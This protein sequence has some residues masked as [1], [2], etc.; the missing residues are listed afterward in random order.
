[1]A[2]D[3]SKESCACRG[4]RN[5]RLCPCLQEVAMNAE[6][7]SRCLR[8]GSGTFLERRRAVVGVSLAAMG[9]LGLIALYQIGVIAHLPDPPLPGFDADKVHGSA[10]AYAR[11]ATPDAVLGL[12]SYVTT[13]MLAAMGD[14]DRATL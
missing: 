13:L 1:M 11:L 9:S 8:Q 4:G 7:L 10:Q 6:E 5:R 14:A 3:A 12:G 2:G